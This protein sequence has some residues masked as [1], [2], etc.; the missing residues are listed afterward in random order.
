MTPAL[1]S[2]ILPLQVLG[3]R[4]LSRL[5]FLNWTKRNCMIGE[6]LL[7]RL[8]CIGVLSDEDQRAVRSLKGDIQNVGRQKEI[9]RPGDR[10]A[11]AI[12]VLRGFL[13][14]YVD[15]SNG[16]RQIVAFYLPTDTPTLETLHISVVDDNLAA[17]V[18]SRIGIVRHDHL[19]ALINER[20]NVLHL[21]WRQ[22][23]IEASMAR[24]W[25]ARNARLP[26][27]M[28]MAHL[29]CEIFLRARSVGL[30]DFNS[31]AVPVT[32]DMLG[33]AL[34]LTAVHVNRTMRSLR[35]TGM[36]DHR[37]GRLHI[38]DFERL[39]KFAEFDPTYLHLRRQVSASATIMLKT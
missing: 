11:S 20:P 4:V 25:M 38:D 3:P 6:A 15:R 29:F 33:Q 35:D 39:A 16:R 31:C 17:A 19:N 27:R 5:A 13:Q 22:T 23:L 34:G 1:R 37:G 2:S 26:A 36:V 32:Q 28:A 21:I 18:E 30:V 9:L 8:L 14:R 24:E 10:P 12:V 7:R